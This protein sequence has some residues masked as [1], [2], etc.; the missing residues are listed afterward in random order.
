MS[1]IYVQLGFGKQWDL[2]QTNGNPAQSVLIKSY[3]KVIKEEQ[4][5][6]RVLPQQAKPMFMTKL[7]TVFA[8]IDR[9]LGRK[10]LTLR[11]K[12]V[13]V[14]DQAFFK[15]QFFPV[16]G[17]MTY[18]IFCHRMLKPF[19][20][21]QASYFVTHLEK[22]LRGNNHTNVFVVRRCADRQI[23]AIHGLEQYFKR[24]DAWGISCQTAFYFDRSQKT[25]WF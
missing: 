16:T 25:A 6:A 5:K 3:L 17:P 24:A 4:A 2:F 22:T 7:R 21:T 15:L 14:R 20:M 12:F 19:V 1:E 9:E 10:D 13:L 23:C 18:R 8:Y 11:E